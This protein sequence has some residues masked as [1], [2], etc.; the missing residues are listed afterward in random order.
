MAKKLFL[1][2]LAT[3]LV[4]GFSFAQ[5]P[6]QTP[7][8]KAKKKSD[9]IVAFIDAGIKKKAFDEKKT[10]DPKSLLN[11]SQKKAVMTACL[12]YELGLDTMKTRKE[13]IAKG[14][15]EMRAKADEVN[16]K[17]TALNAKA[18][19]TVESE[20][21]ANKIKAEVEQGKAEVDKMNSE[22][23]Q[24][25]ANLAQEV[26]SLKAYP[27]ELKN[28]RDAEIKKALNAEQNKYYDD[29]KAKQDKKGS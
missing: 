8:Q 26:E 5:T 2:L 23:E 27:D 14:Q 15:G 16:G 29:M 18:S 25:K 13:A 21:E 24:M 6:A 17:I 3:L 7:E 19:T 1:S 10:A 22:I 9:Q 28:R 12:N 20:E 4:V 11:A